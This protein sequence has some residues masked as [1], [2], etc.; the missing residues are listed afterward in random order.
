MVVLNGLLKRIGNFNGMKKFEDRL[1]L[2]K[3]IYLLQAFDL[4]I[5]YKFSWYIHG[6]YCTELTRDGYSILEIKGNK[7]IT[8]F[9]DSGDEEKFKKFL[10]F[11]GDKKTDPSWLEIISSIHFL[12]K[13][14]PNLDREEILMIVE[15]KQPEFKK[16]DC[17][18]GWNYLES[19]D[20]I[21]YE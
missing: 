8:L 4:Y 1:I 14:Y 9:S 5:G 17:I 3:T 15:N 2:Q 6:P 19:W 12:N 21:K 18:N 11:L 10:K 7:T 16:E 13:V 20:L